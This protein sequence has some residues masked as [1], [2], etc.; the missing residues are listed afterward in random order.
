MPGFFAALALFVKELMLLGR[1]VRIR[2][3]PR[4]HAGV[5]RYGPARS[6]IRVGEHSRVPCQAVDERTGISWVTVTGQAVRAN[7]VEDDQYDV[8]PVR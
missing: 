2:V 3:E 7:R 4:E 5:G 8:H 6:G 1:S